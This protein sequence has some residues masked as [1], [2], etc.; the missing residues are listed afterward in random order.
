MGFVRIGRNTLGG[1]AERRSDGTHTCPFSVEATKSTRTQQAPSGAA[2]P[3]R[4][5]D[6]TMQ[7]P[8]Q[9]GPPLTKVTTRPAPRHRCRALPFWSPQVTSSPLESPS[10]HPFCPTRLGF[11]ADRGPQ[12]SRHHCPESKSHVSRCMP[13]HQRGIK[14]MKSKSSDEKIGAATLPL[15][16]RAH[17]ARRP[18]LGTAEWP[19]DHARGLRRNRRGRGLIANRLRGFDPAD[20]DVPDR[21]G[22]GNR[23]F[24]QSLSF[25]TPNGDA[26]D[27]PGAINQDVGVFC[28][29]SF[30]CPVFG[31]RDQSD[32]FLSRL[33]V[34]A[35]TAC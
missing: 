29:G 5:R 20:A 27:L 32:S 9:E 17:G 8:L 34:A 21:I 15:A 35:A 28:R 4:R 25:F 16:R 26:Q 7:N 6:P 11:F 24:G 13:A 3:P 23:Q 31:G 1:P 19:N 10:V 18:L 22:A 14:T 12:R 33:S 2:F 30:V